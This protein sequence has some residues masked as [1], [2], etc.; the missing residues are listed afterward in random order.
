MKATLVFPVKNNQIL[1]ARKMKKVG[2]GKWNGFGGKSEPEDETVRDTA[3]RELYEET[4]EGIKTKR[5]DLIPKAVIDFYF[6]KNNSKEPDFSVAIYFTENFEGEAVGTD[7][8]QDPTW[9]SFKDVPYQEMLPADRDFIPK[10][11]GDKTFRGKVRFTEGMNDVLDS[12]Y[13]EVT[14]EI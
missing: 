5:E 4:G 6:F 1:L 8:M 14:I 7:E 12:N 3:C 9:F 13:E 10:L 11:F 2:A